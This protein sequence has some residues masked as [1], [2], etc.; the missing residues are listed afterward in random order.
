MDNYLFDDTILTRDILLKV[1]FKPKSNSAF[2]DVI[3]DGE[4]KGNYDHTYPVSY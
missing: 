4:G 1:G 2:S 3:F